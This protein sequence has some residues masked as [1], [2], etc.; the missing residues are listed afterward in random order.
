MV[1]SVPHLVH[2]L[3]QN[4]SSTVERNEV[5]VEVAEIEPVTQLYNYLQ[6]ASN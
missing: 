5:V 1:P 6:K 4:T 2:S 3:Q